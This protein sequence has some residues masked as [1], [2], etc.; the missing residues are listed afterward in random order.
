MSVFYLADI[1]YTFLGQ[2]LFANE[3]LTV[4][5][6]TASGR[7]GTALFEAQRFMTLVDA[8]WNH[9]V[10]KGI[11]SG[12]AII[13]FTRDRIEGLSR[14]KTPIVVVKDEGVSDKRL[15]IIEAELSH[16]FKVSERSGNSLTAKLREAYDCP[17][18]LQNSNKNSPET[19]TN[20]YVSMI[21]HITEAELKTT[22]PDNIVNGY[23]NRNTYV[24]AFRAQRIPNPRPIPWPQDLV[25]ELAR[26]VRLAQAPIDISM[27]GGPL[28][29][30]DESVRGLS[31][32]DPI[33][34][35]PFDEEAQILWNKLHAENDTETGPMSAILERRL[36]HI[37]KNAL[38]YAIL[39][40]SPVMT[41]AHLLAGVAIQDHSDA[42]ASSVFADF[43]S[44]KLAN[45]IITALKRTSPEGLPKTQIWEDVARNNASKSEMDEALA[46]LSQS[47]L[48]HVTLKKF[49]PKAKKPT[50][51]WFAGAKSSQ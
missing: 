8:L 46:F 16:F 32:P 1:Y 41:S 33:K 35:I 13:H 36:A 30:R 19:A 47:K 4:L 20:A 51:V 21:G 27:V 37:R 40:R 39:D 28:A 43:S 25:D 23:I 48:A 34:E 12:E 18:L 15:L 42:L 6:D 31:G 11:Q 49:D 38:K 7:K 26:T 24:H 45:K 50:Q 17:E 22:N 5:G 3:F 14:G 2:N 9:K 44:N 10:R 29:P